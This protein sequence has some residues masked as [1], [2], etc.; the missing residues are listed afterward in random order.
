M[1]RAFLLSLIILLSQPLASAT[2]TILEDSD[3][4]STGTL[5]GN[6]SISEGATWTISGDYEIE[7]GTSIVVEE[8]ATMV[9]SGSMDA[10]S[11][12]QLNLASTANV[13]VPVGYLGESGVV[14]IDFAETVQF[15]ITIEIDNMS[16]TDWTG[17]QFDWNGSLDVDDI[18]INITSHPFQIIAI[19]SVTLSA[20][21]ATPVLVDA[22][23]LSGEGTSLVI[24]DRTNAW[25]IDVQG[26]LIVTG[27][28]F[29]ASISCAGTCTLDG[30]QMASTGPIDVTG[31][32]SVTDT[33]LAG[34]V[35]DEDIILWDDAEISWSNSTG[36]GGLTDN[37]V[38]I[39]TTRTVG[40]QNGYVVFYG[41]GMGYDSSDTSPLTDN[42]TLEVENQGDGIIEIGSNERM[43]MVRWQD[44]NGV[45][46][47]ESA[48]GKIVLAT[49]WG[50]YEHNITNLPH[51]NHF[52]VE[53]DLP[54]LSFDS[55]EASDDEGVIN[56]R[57][58]VM[59]TV[60]N[61]GEVPGTF[62]IDCYYNNGDYVWTQ[63][64]IESLLPENNYGN[65]VAG[66]NFTATHL[67]EWNLILDLDNQRIRTDTF[68][69]L[70]NLGI[71][72]DKKID[73]N[74]GS[75]STHAIGA[76]ETREIPLN[77]DSP[78]EGDLVLE[79]NI[80]IPDE[81]TG[82][83]V[84]SDNSGNASTESVSWSEVEDNSTNL[85]L[86][87]SIGVIVAIAI[88]VVMAR[89]KLNEDEL[90][91]HLTEIEVSSEDETADDEVG[92]IE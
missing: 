66:S 92:T 19:S 67:E 30:A 56:T 69:D 24:P 61:S 16:T 31:S 90:K 87:I 48:S 78:I 68:E 20:Q 32:I 26:T 2:V 84:L 55:L 53:L 70:A 54:L 14:R 58:G 51:V 77:W 88:Y 47:L 57:L 18:T 4:D 8:G 39:L 1:R 74:V 89:K 63:A 15:G 45:E 37:W 33:T 9:V 21:G 50:I 40:V 11:P 64:G 13:S 62:I 43:K 17:S 44:G 41:Y 27:S 6:Y 60:T 25:D 79:C 3:E 46:H 12:P 52:D 42:H 59:A 49:P 35:T 76:G 81:F 23:G 86:P 34:G 28:V 65:P 5:S 85:I 38:N 82:I 7:V 91:E 73:A 71:I 75:T 22:T 10:I 83:T 29:G 72:V 80:W 36:T